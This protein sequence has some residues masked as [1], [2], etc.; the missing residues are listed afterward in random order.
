MCLAPKNH[1]KLKMYKSCLILSNYFLVLDA[2]RGKSEQHHAE[3][4]VSLEV[5]TEIL[6]DSPDC[7]TSPIRKK[8]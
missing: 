4:L 6:M 1:M 2:L 7:S 5:K 3:A 8:Y